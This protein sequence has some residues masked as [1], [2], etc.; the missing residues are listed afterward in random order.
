MEIRGY[1]D[2]REAGR[3]LAAAL[4]SEVKL[5]NPLILALPR[6]GITVAAEVAR[7]LEAELDVL[8]VRK[9]GHPL[10]QELAIGALAEG[11]IQV[12]NPET[13]AAI[14]PEVIRS[15]VMR[16]SRELERRSARYRAGAPLPSLRA[17][18]VVLVD[19]GLATGATMRA[20]VLAAR[21]GGARQVV[22]AV[23]VGD[24]SVC[25]SLGREADRVVCPLQPET[26]AAVGYWYEEFSQVTDDEVSAALNDARRRWSETPQQP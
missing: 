23:P 19:D 2:R 17:R 16:E 26:L 18:D 1:S 11:N 13:A 5:E 9:L 3:R 20:A 7:E 24:P 8:V 25:A 14:S 15:I 12:L 21:Q 10:Q 6:G 4:R 22:V